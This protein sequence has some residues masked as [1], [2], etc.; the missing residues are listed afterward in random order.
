VSL[1][2][3]TPAGKEI[4]G[5]IDLYMA[6]RIDEIFSSMT[7]FEREIVVRS[8][9]LLNGALT[10]AGCCGVQQDKIA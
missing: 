4:M 2:G 10:K 6:K 5:R 1:L 3:L 7:D 8:P 9:A